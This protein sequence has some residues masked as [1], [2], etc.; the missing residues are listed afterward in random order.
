MAPKPY[1]NSSFF[2]PAIK[3][4]LIFVER[5][6]YATKVLSNLPGLGEEIVRMFD[7]TTQ[8]SELATSNYATLLST[9]KVTNQKFISIYMVVEI[10]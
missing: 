8:R 3:N 10:K 2:Y 4:F 9:Q 5:K 7:Q 1:D 6:S